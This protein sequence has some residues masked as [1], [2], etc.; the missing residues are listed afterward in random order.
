VQ[1]RLV[2][3]AL[4]VLNVAAGAYR[5]AAVDPY[6]V[7]LMELDPRVVRFGHGTAETIGT[8]RE[9]VGFGVEREGGRRSSPT[10]EELRVLEA[11]A[12][13]LA[14]RAGTFEA[15]ALALRALLDL[16]HHRERGAAAQC[17]AAVTLLKEELAEIR[18]DTSS[19]VVADELDREEI[20]AIARHVLEVAGAYHA[21][22][23]DLNRADDA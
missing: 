3:Q 11:V 14:G 19:V 10:T 4:D 21:T 6:V 5:A 12:A 18:V 15:E 20:E 8:G 1:R 9:T 2:H 16:A 13:A 17:R 7:E 23:A 22:R